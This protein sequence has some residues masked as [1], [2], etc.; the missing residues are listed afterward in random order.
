MWCEHPLFV[1]VRGENLLTNQREGLNELE[2][3]S[4]W[5]IHCPII[6][7][8]RSFASL[9]I[10][11]LALHFLLSFC[12]LSPSY[13]F[14]L[15]LISCRWWWHGGRGSGLCGCEVVVVAVVLKQLKNAPLARIWTQGRWW[16]WKTGWKCWKEPPPACIWT[17][18]RWQRHWNVEK[19]TSSSRLDARVVV[20]VANEL[21]ILKKSTSGLRLDA[22]EVVVM[23]KVLK[24][25]KT[26]HPARIWMQGRWRQWEM[27]WKVRKIHLQLMFG[28]EGGGGGG[29]QVETS[30][31]STSCSCLDVKEVV[32]MADAWKIEKR[33]PGSHLDA[34]EVVIVAEV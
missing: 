27:R 3:D 31:K 12:H 7:A 1:E 22:R 15:W 33:P 24:P 14:S 34:R 5:I 6:D 8:A 28:H 29:R 16:S 30:K 17:W 11:L 19:T 21:K 32:V 23:A 20:V 18:G 9:P 10:I 13:P 26:P 2:W 4:V 25:V